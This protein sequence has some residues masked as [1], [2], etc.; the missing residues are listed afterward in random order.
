MS[1]GLS[2]FNIMEVSTP[3][4]RTAAVLP[5]TNPSAIRM[6]EWISVNGMA[7]WAWLTALAARRPAGIVKPR[8][9]SRRCNRSRARA[10]LP[11]IARRRP[12]MLRCLS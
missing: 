4:A 10:S 7:A 3:R 11:W 8:R 5:A 2:W 12:L 6:V 1:P 9:I